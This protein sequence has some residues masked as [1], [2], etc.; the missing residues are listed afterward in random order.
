[1]N[2]GILPNEPP[3]PIFLDWQTAGY[4]SPILDLAWLLEKDA[5]EKSSL[6]KEQAVAFYYQKL[7]ERL[8][9]RF[10]L[11]LWPSMLELG[12]LAHVLR[13]GSLY[14]WLSFQ[15]KDERQV[16]FRQ[17]GLEAINEQVRVGAKWLA[18]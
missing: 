15:D 17:A 18:T 12:W 6:S 8:G 5:V 16:A 13:W 1:M 2:L 7:V 3:R 11:S 9:D 10:D 14:A 4:S